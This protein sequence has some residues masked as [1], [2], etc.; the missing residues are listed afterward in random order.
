MSFT[1]KRIVPFMGCFMFSLLAFATPQDSVL[2]LPEVRVYSLKEEVSQRPIQVLHKK[3]LERINAIQ[4]SD[5]LKTFSGLVI[6]DYGGIGGLK[7]ISARSLGVQHTAISYDGVLLS[8]AQNGWIDLG[9]IPTENLQNVA[10]GQGQLN[11]IFVPA[12][13]FASASV[14]A[15]ETQA[16]SFQDN[17]INTAQIGLKYGSFGLLNPS[18]Q[19]AH[20]VNSKIVLN[21][22]LN[23]Q[24]AE[25][26]YPFTL[27]NGVA[28]QEQK[29]ENTNSKALLAEGN[30]YYKVSPKQ[31]LDL[32]IYG[33][34]SQR[35]LPGAVIYYN[36]AGH[37][38]LEDEI[39]FTQAKHQ[40]AF[41]DAWKQKIIL[42]YQNSWQKYT[43][44]QW[45]TN[46]KLENIYTQKEL[47]A[48]LVE[49]FKAG[50][51]LDFSTSFDYTHNSLEANVSNFS[52]PTR[53]T[54]LGNFASQ[55][56][57]SYYDFNAN[58][59]GLSTVESVEKGTAATSHQKLS[60]ALFFALRPWG[61]ED[62]SIRTFYKESYRLPTFN[63]LYYTLI[64]TRTLKPETVQQYNLGFSFLQC[65]AKDYVL[66]SVDMYRNYLI[67]KIVA[68]PSGNLYAWS[69]FNVDK[70]EVTGIDAHVKGYWQVNS[71]W[72]TI[73]NLTYT[74]QQSL[75]MSDPNSQT[76]KNQVAYTPLHS[77]SASLS[78]ERVRWAISYQM[79][80]TGW[81][82]SA[83]QNITQNYM[84]GY[85]DHSLLLKYNFTVKRMKYTL[86]TEALNIYN[87]QYEVVKNYP[88]PGRSFRIKIQ[89]NI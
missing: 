60:P 63:D 69:M 13:Y 32:K 45:L 68:Y 34:D 51:N 41:T 75:D 86:V 24:Q 37:Q 29:R 82:Y 83:N 65:T 1:H 53:Q 85:G 71:R 3:D 16:P 54:Y 11:T 49:G 21:T 77:G 47:Y 64:G 56:Y 78:A 6:K 26:A 38:M 27:Y 4:L 88:M 33:Y 50:N 14:L 72:A 52:Y 5:A 30:L 2:K 35:G 19:Y 70:V 59:L 61:N 43:D 9:R 40:L 73:A 87:T 8:D 22:Y 55:Y 62:F 10:L 76:Y 80:W 17:K 48:S 15:L 20:K 46:Q 39:Y 74:Y 67:N 12:K 7:T 31:T 79:L 57:T 18:V 36:S 81:R 25:G 44:P 42:K 89:C 23:Y 84:D 66:G 28:T 58:I